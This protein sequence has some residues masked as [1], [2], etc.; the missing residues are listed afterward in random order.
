[1]KTG[2]SSFPG[3]VRI[4]L[5]TAGL[6]LASGPGIATGQAQERQDAIDTRQDTRQDSREI[7]VDCR[8][9]DQQRATLNVARISVRTSRKVVMRRVTSNT[10]TDIKSP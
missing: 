4:A 5:V 7:K 1:M 2:N 3:A 10:D 6:L 8:A 9:A